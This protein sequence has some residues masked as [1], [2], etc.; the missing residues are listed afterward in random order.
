V[1]I[2]EL[3]LKQPN[4]LQNIHIIK[5]L[6]SQIFIALLELKLQYSYIYSCVVCALRAKE[7][8]SFHA[9]VTGYTRGLLSD[10]I[11]E[12]DHARLQDAPKLQLKQPNL[13]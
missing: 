11:P 3:Q 12:V 7:R 9:C 13:G 5:L 6:V 2:T 4:P 10:I 8:S 1:Q